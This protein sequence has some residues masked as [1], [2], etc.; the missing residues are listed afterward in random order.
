MAAVSVHKTL[1]SANE[2]AKMH[3]GRET[4]RRDENSGIEASVLSQSLDKNGLFTCQLKTSEDTRDNFKIQVKKMQL[5]GD[6]TARTARPAHGNEN[7]DTTSALTAAQPV[8][9]L[10]E[11]ICLD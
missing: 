8:H 5:H 3:M 4:Q 9:K 6:P 11:V 1:P 10:H 2:A 7:T